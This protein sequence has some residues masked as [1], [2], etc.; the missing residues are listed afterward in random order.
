LQGL[1]VVGEGR[2]KG[3]VLRENGIERRSEPTRQM[4]RDYNSGRQ[5]GWKLAC[6][7]AQGINPAR[8]RTDGQ[9][10][11]IAHAVSTQPG[12]IHET[13]AFPGWFRLAATARMFAH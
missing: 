13:T 3:S 12:P 10:V 1:A 4:D 5:A 7:K 6:Q 8:R 11:A 2:R 9:N